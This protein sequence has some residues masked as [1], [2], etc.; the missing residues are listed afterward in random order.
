MAAQRN[1]IA[2]NV[3]EGEAYKLEGRLLKSLQLYI[4]D[5]FAQGFFNSSNFLNLS[6]TL[7]HKLNVQI[8]FCKTYQAKTQL[9]SSWFQCSVQTESLNQTQ[10]V[11]HQTGE[12]F[13]QAVFLMGYLLL[14]LLHKHRRQENRECKLVTVCNWHGRLIRR[15]GVPGPGTQQHQGSIC[16]QPS[17]LLARKKDGGL[18]VIIISGFDINP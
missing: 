17:W 14:F 4:P 8:R 5:I 15:L 12:L 16:C 3:K 10:L 13:Y 1:F 7:N 18:T 2:I 6:N 9:T 11:L